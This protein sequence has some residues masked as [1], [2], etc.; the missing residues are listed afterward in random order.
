MTLATTARCGGDRPRRLRAARRSRVRR[1]RGCARPRRRSEP[2]R[3]RR[4]TIPA[5]PSTSRTPPPFGTGMPPSWSAAGDHLRHEAGGRLIRARA[6]CAAP[7]ARGGRARASDSNVSSSQSRQL[8]SVLPANS[9]RPRRPRRRSALRPSAS[10]AVDQSSVPRTPKREV[11]VGHELVEL[12]L[13]GGAVAGRE[14]VELRHVALERGRDERRRA[15]GERGSGRQVGVD[16]LDAR[17]GRARPSARR[18]R[19]SR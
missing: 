12:P 3:P 14:A 15:V 9:S 8:T 5:R 4:V 18:R 11:G 17:G 1:R 10:P 7:M 19:R 6:R 2:R 13:P 16:V